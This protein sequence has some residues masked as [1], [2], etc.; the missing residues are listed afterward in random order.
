[1]AN[2]GRVVGNAT[3]IGGSLKIEKGGRVDGDVGVAGGSLKRED[4]AIVGGRIVDDRHHGKVKIRAGDKGVT[5][6]V[7]EGSSSGRSRLSA[8]AH[9]FGRSLT[10]MALLFVLGCVLLALAAPRME[11]LR[12][13][14]ASRP[15]RS[16]AL[17]I[18]GA[19]LGSIAGLVLTTILSITIIGIPVAIAGILFAVLALYGAIASVLT[20]FGAAVAG[21]RTQNP[22]VHLL[23]GCGAFLVLSSIPWVGGIVTFVVTMIALGALVTTRAGGLFDRRKA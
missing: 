8:A 18:V 19:I 9:E 10:R 3:V 16:F 14:I 23:I 7:S 4:G 5:T 20:T 6:E 12:V 1:V 13:E 17:G 2:G 21:H 11:K 22:Y 15:M